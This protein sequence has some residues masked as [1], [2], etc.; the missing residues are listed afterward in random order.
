MEKPY[1]NMTDMLDELEENYME[2][3]YG[4]P[5]A[6]LGDTVWAERLPMS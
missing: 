6:F 1:N 2:N 5:Y 4:G 3:A